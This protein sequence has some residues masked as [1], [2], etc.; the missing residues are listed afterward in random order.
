MDHLSIV[1]LGAVCAGFVQG[2]SGFAFGLTAM[3]FWVWALDPALA[4]ALAVFGSLTG[5][6]ISAL[7]VR[8]GHHWARL[9][10]FLAGGAVGVPIG[11]LLLPAL[12]TTLF[13]AM[14]GGLLVIWCPAMLFATRLPAISF[15][16]RVADGVVGMAG[17]VM[18]GLGGFTGVMPT[19]WCTLRRLPKDEQ[20]VIVQ[21]FN[22]AML[23]F[24]MGA[25]LVRGLVTPAMLPLFA[26][27]GVAIVVPVL[28][29]GRLYIGLSEA[30][31]RQ[32]VL[33]LL[34]ASGVAMLT[35]SLPRLLDH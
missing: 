34:T 19:L 5:Q 24:T 22:L 33:T 21:N 26:I 4:A 3:S 32:L 27:V 10:P 31:F 11:V 17:G 13:K 16:G 12:D 30:R 20:R 14:L 9:S 29:G 18:G 6:V 35:S 1:V 2:L 25:Y 15:G 7:T 28:L 8:R 23:M